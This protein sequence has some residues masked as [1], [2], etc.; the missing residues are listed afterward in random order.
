MNGS[1]IYTYHVI[2]EI[3]GFYAIFQFKIY[4]ICW[5]LDL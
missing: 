2:M 3:W 5:A 4:D 1:K